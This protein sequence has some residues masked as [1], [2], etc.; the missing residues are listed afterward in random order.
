MI[1]LSIV[2]VLVLTYFLFREN[3]PVVVY[4]DRDGMFKKAEGKTGLYELRVARKVPIPS[5]NWRAVPTNVT[6]APFGSFV[7]RGRQVCLFGN[8][9][10]RVYSVPEVKMTGAEV[11]PYVFNDLPRKPIEVI[12]TNLNPNRPYIAREG[13][14][15][16]YLEVFRV[17]S[18]H[19]FHVLKEVN[20][21]RIDG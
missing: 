2:F 16:A 18:Y 1:V 10:C 17:P 20:D 6:I 3:L 4:T 21:D 15:I 11:M 5:Y 9:G 19:L 7:Y 14:I 8:V 12:V 13:E